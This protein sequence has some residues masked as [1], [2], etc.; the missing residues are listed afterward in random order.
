M[1]NSLEHYFLSPSLSQ[2]HPSRTKA[3]ARLLLPLLLLQ[4][5]IIHTPGAGEE[6]AIYVVQV[7]VDGP[8]AFQHEHAENFP[9][10]R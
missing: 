4:V 6:R 1:F 8:V 10:R 9:N 5:A 7:E 2:I 3:F